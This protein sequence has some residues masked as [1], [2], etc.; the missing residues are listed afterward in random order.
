MLARMAVVLKVLLEPEQLRNNYELRHYRFSH[1]KALAQIGLDRVTL[2]SQLL[3]QMLRLRAKPLRQ[4][5][6]IPEDVIT[7]AGAYAAQL[8][9]KG[10]LYKDRAGWCGEI[11]ACQSGYC[12]GSDRVCGRHGARQKLDNVIH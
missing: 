2:I 5:E 12:R 1:H 10:E 7:S 6:V 3:R 4:F 8:A 11:R 9:A